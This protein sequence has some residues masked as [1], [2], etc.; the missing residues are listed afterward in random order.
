MAT[1]TYLSASTL[2]QVDV[3]RLIQRVSDS[4]TMRSINR[5]TYLL[6][7]GGKLTESVRTAV[8][9][10]VVCF[11]AC[12]RIVKLTICNHE[13]FICSLDQVQI[14]HVVNVATPAPE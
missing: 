6:T 10:F 8:Y 7:Y 13:F 2:V 12:A 3:Y 4:T 5:R 1:P 9:I 11:L 14:A